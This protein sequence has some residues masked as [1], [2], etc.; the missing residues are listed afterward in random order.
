MNQ[1]SPT[2]PEL[3]PS[4]LPMAI[5]DGKPS[6]DLPPLGLLAKLRSNLIQAPLFALFTGVFGSVALAA[7]LFD[8][9]G[10]SEHWLA[11]R[12]AR[13]LTVIAG[14]PVTVIGGEVLEQHP[15]AVYAANHLSYMDTPVLFGKLPFQFRILARHDLW[16]LPFVGWYLGRSGQIPVN[17]DNPRA[18]FSSLK[19]G[20]RT[21]KAGMPLFVFPEGGRAVD[22]HLQ[23]FKSG[24]A[25]MAIHAQVP[26]VPIAL[27]G[28]HELFPMHTYYFRPRPVTIVVGTPISTKG[29]ITREADALTERLREAIATM[30]YEHSTLPAPAPSAYSE[31]L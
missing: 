6:P 20:V 22:G 11:Q 30:Y 1:N 15:V 19:A 26:L 17:L 9:S 2:A 3:A 16:K 14:A 31:K 24:P 7:S 23:P 27:I 4:P 29:M 28:T 21:L 12:W 18:S 25:F 13:C 8:K 10:Y 5:D